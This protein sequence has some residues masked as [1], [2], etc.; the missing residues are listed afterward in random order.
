M[1]RKREFDIINMRV[2]RRR[3][4]KDRIIGK[5]RKMGLELERCVRTKTEQTYTFHEQW[6]AY[7][8][9]RKFD[10]ELQHCFK[11]YNLI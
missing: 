1:K 4:V 10:F 5:K 2:K 8:A 6:H 7:I 3:V 11:M 9:R